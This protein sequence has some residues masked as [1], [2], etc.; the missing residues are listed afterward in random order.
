MAF[1]Y[2]TQLLAIVNCDFKL[3]G[4]VHGL[5]TVNTGTDLSLTGAD[6]LSLRDDMSL[7]GCLDQG[8]AR[9]AQVF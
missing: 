9:F 1:L 8:F 4:S 3:K 5:H 7:H 2:T 6:Q